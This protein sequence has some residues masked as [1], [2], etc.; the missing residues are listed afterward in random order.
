MG[1]FR[2]RDATCT[3]A[4]NPSAKRYVVTNPPDDFRLM[5]TDKASDVILCNELILDGSI[6][7]R[8]QVR[9]EVVFPDAYLRVQ[10]Q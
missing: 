5:P 2:F 10:E 7:N 6:F 9:D 4:Q 8:F 1:V 3:I